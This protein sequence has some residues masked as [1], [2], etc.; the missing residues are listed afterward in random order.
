MSYDTAMEE[1]KRANIFPDSDKVKTGMVT[2]DVTDAELELVLN[3]ERIVGIKLSD[4]QKK[5]LL[6]KGN[7]NVIA[8]AGSGKTSTT[9]LLLAKRIMTG[10]IKNT[11]KLVCTTYSKG[12]ATEME[13][14]LHQILKL[15]GVDRPIKVVTLHAF[16]LSIIRTFGLTLDIVKD[17]GER[18]RFIRES[19]KDANFELR[20]DDLATLSNLIS[21]QVNNL[22]S[23]KKA[24]ESEANTLDNL[25]LEKYAMIRKGYAV[26]KASVGKIDFDD[27]Q[28]YL[29][30]WLVK[31]KTSDNEAERASALNV[32]NYCKAMWDDFFI[33]EAQDISKIQFAI[34]REM[35]ADPNDKGKLDKGLVF[36]GDDDQ[37]IYQWRGADP[38]IILNI[39]N[40]FDL[41]L[42]M[43]STNYRCK[44]NIVNFAANSVKNNVARYSKEI[45][46]FNPGGSVKIAVSD[47]KDLNALSNIAVGY[48]K[49]LINKGE[50]ARD[51]CVMSR[52]NFHLAILSNMLLHDGIYTSS[53]ADMKLTNSSM[54]K[55]LKCILNLCVDSYNSYNTRNILWKLCR[56]MSIAMSNNI[57]KFQDETGLTFID[58][59]TYLLEHFGKDPDVKLGRN[60]KMPI[61]V[62]KS[63]EYQW[64]RLSPE[65]VTNIKAIWLTFTMNKDNIT[66]I[67]EDLMFMYLNCAGEL[68]YKREDKKRS[69]KGL[70][71]YLILMS[72]K[73]G[74]EN[75]MEFLRITEQYESGTMETCGDKVTLTTV[76]S[77]KGKEWKNVIAFACDNVTM[78]SQE[79][80]EK[81]ISEGQSI[82]DINNYIDE[83][84]RLYY[85]EMTRAKENL[86]VITYSNP[87]IFIMESLGAKI[88]KGH[89]T[90][91]ELIEAYSSDN[92]FKEQACEKLFDREVINDKLLNENS[93]FYFKLEDR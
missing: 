40:T 47:K 8:C 2:N 44:E 61:Q 10:E 41:D 37:T 16:F 60:I 19:A 5:I 18:M 29:Y 45:K 26:R 81:M 11:N 20:D 58:A 72:R 3:M 62:E 77:A 89:G 90:N 65:T 33:D 34:I 21:Y 87:S 86:L 78:P 13:D 69:I 83:E 17:E 54:Y 30:K 39:G 57:G 51:I 84:R 38:S 88:G 14:R 64:N 80:I 66:K 52:N 46:A 49:S 27:M 68:L 28:M 82:H 23:D 48:I 9:V 36:V 75:M 22:M 76:H 91:N 70:C 12:G 67:A 35:I 25:T 93:E 24:L 53:T 73:D 4:E 92:Y 6:N 31:D 15:F 85:V 1:L 43:L 50:N 32:R 63:M 42:K 55:D 7:M 79:N 59:I 71:N 56:Y 74:Y